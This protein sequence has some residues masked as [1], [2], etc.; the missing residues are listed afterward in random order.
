[1]AVVAHLDGLLAT[2]T[3]S[4]CSTFKTEPNK[5]AW[6]QIVHLRFLS[7]SIAW[8]SLESSSQLLHFLKVTAEAGTLPKI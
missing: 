8:H 7:P 5:C 6:N 1:M 2:R 4:T 3:D